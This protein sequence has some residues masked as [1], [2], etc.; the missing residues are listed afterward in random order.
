MVKSVYCDFSKLP[1]EAGFQKW[2]GYDDVK[3]AP[4]YFY[5]QRNSPFNTT[6]SPDPFPDFPTQ[7][8]QR[9]EFVDG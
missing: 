5:V 8:R 2:I 4:V 3:S 9:H 6:K 1:N 7:H